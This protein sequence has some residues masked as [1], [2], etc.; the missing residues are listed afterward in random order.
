MRNDRS[1]SV[2]RGHGGY[3]NRHRQVRMLSSLIPAAASRS[4]HAAPTR[5][6]P[7]HHRAAPRT[8][9]TRPNQKE[10]HGTLSTRRPGNRSPHRAADRRRQCLA[11]QDRADPG[12]ALQIWHRQYPPR[13]WRLGQRRPEGLAGEAA[14]LRH[15]PDPAVQLFNRQERDGYRARDRRDGTALHPEARRLL[16]RL[17][18]CGF[19]AV[20]HAAQ[21]ERP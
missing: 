5:P 15:P 1:H 20:G 6:T 13:L 9:G 17:E 18:R 8:S 12:R 11:H 3:R 19:H 7:P 14:R 21:G 10:N 4:T 16:H 2:A